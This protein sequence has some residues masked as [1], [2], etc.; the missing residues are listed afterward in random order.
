MCS[1]VS[2]CCSRSDL[3]IITFVGIVVHSLIMQSLINNI[4]V[5]V[6][7]TIDLY[8]LTNIH[9]HVFLWL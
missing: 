4:F 8:S 9:D 1:D 3:S 2:F 6:L 5:D 7:Y